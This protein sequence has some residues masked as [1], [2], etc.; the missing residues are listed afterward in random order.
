VPLFCVLRDAAV[1]GG[2]ELLTA[3]CDLCSNS[4]CISSRQRPISLTHLTA[5]YKHWS[6]GLLCSHYFQ[7]LSL[8]K[9]RPPVALRT[10]ASIVACSFSLRLRMQPLTVSSLG[11]RRTGL[12][13]VCKLRKVRACIMHSHTGFISR[14][15]ERCYWWGY[16]YNG[17]V[18]RREV[19]T[20]HD[21]W[22]TVGFAKR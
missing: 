16:K 18:W 22:H 21:G 7:F 20:N 12:R 17:T 15:L 11:T 6:I 14:K 2:G 10:C 9:A 13:Y 4:R 5:L 8:D 1:S 3:Q 19:R